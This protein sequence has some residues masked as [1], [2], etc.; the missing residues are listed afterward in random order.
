MSPRLSLEEIERLEQGVAEAGDK[1]Q[2]GTIMRLL[3]ELRALREERNEAHIGIVHLQQAC[4][5][6]R[7]ERDSARDN[8]AW[9]FR[10]VKA[11]GKELEDLRAELD[12]LRA[13]QPP[14][15][16]GVLMPETAPSPETRDREQGTA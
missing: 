16:T 9:L 8:Y 11:V 5:S 14:E 1:E 2:H 7:R 3:A 13:S 15:R 4:E 12:A 6:M 10:H